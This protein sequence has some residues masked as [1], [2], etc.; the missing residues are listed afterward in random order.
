MVQISLIPRWQ[1][2]LVLVLLL[3]LVS[4]PVLAQD[5]VHV[6]QRGETLA[7][8][9]RQ[10][11]VSIS[12]LTTYNGIANSDVIF[13]GQ[14]ILV[15]FGNALEET[16]PGSHTVTASDSLVSIAAQ[17]DTTVAELRAANRLNGSPIWVGQ[18]LQL[19]TTQQVG[20]PR[21]HTVQL[22]ETLSSIGRTY[23]QTWQSLA[24]YNGLKDAGSIKFGQTLAIP[25]IDTSRTLTA[26]PPTIRPVPQVSV[27]PAAAPSSHSYVLQLGESLDKVAQRFDVSLADLLKVNGLTVS[28]QIWAGQNLLLPLR[29][30]GSEPLNVPQAIPYVAP[31]EPAPAVPAIPAP[32]P[33]LGQGPLPGESFSQGLA[34]PPA[35]FLHIVKLGET[36]DTIANKYELNPAQ[37]GKLNFLTLGI[38]ISVG[39]HL[40]I[41]FDLDLADE[42]GIVAKR[43][44]EIDLSQQTLTAWEGN[45]L[46]LH[47]DISSGLAN[48]PTPVGRFRVW[49]MNPSQTMSG[50][51]YSLDNVKH[52]M[53]FFSGYAMH[54]AYWHNNFGSPMSH[55]CVNMRE[56]YAEKLYSFASLGMEVWVHN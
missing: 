32:V 14:Q 40:Q 39:Q 12:Q 56:E 49:H 17:Y 44:V 52:N 45:E 23:G 24:I 53:Y 26:A 21:T 47:T 9:S 46:F 55:G 34:H 29:T 2:G 5:K 37:I 54:G 4:A 27:I 1:S 43:W 15:P 51:D 3:S 11:D 42:S 41:P 16:Q 20:Q 36:L 30:D 38:P 33:K 31:A 18:D 48:T 50:P 8:I 10:F 7:S 28:S 6:V 35:N 25:S 19:P 22:G 13:A